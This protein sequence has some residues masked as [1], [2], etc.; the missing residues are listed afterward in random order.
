MSAAKNP[1]AQVR[2][3]QLAYRF[4]DASRWDVNLQRL[5]AMGMRAAI[6]GPRGNG[7]TTLLRELH[8]R[9]SRPT[10]DVKSPISKPFP[11]H[12]E[13]DSHGSLLLNVCRC[14]SWLS[15]E[16]P[17]H[18]VDRK[19]QRAFI[20]KT[21][22]SLNRNTVLLVDGIERM[23][24]IDRQR[25][26]R[27]QASPQRCAGLVITA[28][29]DCRILGLKTWVRA[30]PTA[31]LLNELIAELGVEMKI[32]IESQPGNIRDALRDLY[33]EYAKR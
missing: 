31:N 15:S 11:A 5:R 32:P 26:V 13:G 16:P 6:V 27:F 14:N 33:D 2:L 29:Q 28:H 30:K 22:H 23:T 10:A 19:T 24:W 9:L 12:V 8:R 25:L 18:A 21:L 17:E 4:P 20:E 7:K 1:F 3:E